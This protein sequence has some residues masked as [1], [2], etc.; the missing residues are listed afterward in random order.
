MT[1]RR[2]EN[3]EIVVRALREEVRQ[4][5]DELLRQR[6][7]GVA[8]V[9]GRAGAL[10]GAG[11]ADTSL[12]AEPASRGSANGSVSA[13][14]P[15]VAHDRVAQETSEAGAGGGSTASGTS[16]LMPPTVPNP[17]AG[18]AGVPPD[19]HHT[20][21]AP[22]SR[23]RNHARTILSSS[24]GAGGIELEALIGRYGTLAVAA[25]LVV[26]GVGAFVTWAATRIVIGPTARVVLGA[27]GALALA[28]LGRRLATRGSVAFGSTMLALALAVAHVDAWAAGPVLHV[29]PN[30]VALGA[31]A[32]AS[33]A[34]AAL[35][36]RERN[37][38]LFA[39]GVGGALLAPFVTGDRL[40]PAL[41]LLAY[42]WVVIATALAASRPREWSVTTRLVTVAAAVYT[43]A[44]IGAPNV[45]AADV[46][47][48]GVFPL[49]CAWAAYLWGPDR[50][51]A[52]V[53]FWFVALAAA[54]LLAMSVRDPIVPFIAVAVLGTASSYVL[55]E[56]RAASRTQSI[57]GAVVLPLAFLLGALAVVQFAPSRGTLLAL[58][59]MIAAIALS[60]VSRGQR[61]PH[62]ATASFAAVAAIVLALHDQ[63]VACVT[64]LAAASVG[65]A[66]VARRSD[67]AAALLPLLLALIVAAIWSHLLLAGRA[68]YEYTPF[69]SRESIAAA[70]VVAA[71]FGIWR[72]LRDPPDHSGV[73]QAIVFGAV[74]FLWPRA[75]LQ[76]AIRPEIATFL[77][78]LYYAAFGIV[79]IALGRRLRVSELRI[80]GISLA[81]YA[82]G[83]AVVQ[84]AGLTTI[85]L[86]VGSYLL[87][88]GFLL[89]VAYWYRAAAAP[90]ADQPAAH[91]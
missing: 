43:A 39:V 37:E 20:S 84:A 70:S 34:L 86:R 12:R 21:D 45:D 66:L 90:A 19:F 41:F 29:V 75:E 36:L 87:V 50:Q 71:A 79:A 73:I 18:A 35:A 9:R 1:E 11:M 17:L 2:L 57:I 47:A 85:G 49:A 76:Y 58:G 69:L 82:A 7:A 46:L 22:L 60:R 91:S 40:T 68:A 80:G 16:G 52:H 24:H 38:T 74:L 72:L 8:G 26:M 13:S 4:L 78:I 88:G 32:L 63:P 89:A 23:N 53:S 54:A 3:L 59:W 42:G 6:D 81:L 65:I 56:S 25:V 14:G 64:A 83:K 61:G 55:V 33:V 30:L 10:D 15:I 31:A 48:A 77:L 28:A 62:L 5:R 67:G 44:G 51:R 27:L